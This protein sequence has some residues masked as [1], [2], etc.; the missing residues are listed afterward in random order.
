MPILYEAVLQYSSRMEVDRLR[1]SISVY[2]TQDFVIVNSQLHK[3]FDDRSSTSL[4]VNE[5][6]ELLL[7]SGMMKSSEA[8]RYMER[9]IS[10]CL[11]VKLILW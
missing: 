8:R 1:T 2:A 4:Q 3:E 10:T 6:L 5:L 9:F 11:L 7:Q